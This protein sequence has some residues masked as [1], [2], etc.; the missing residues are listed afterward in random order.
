MRWIPI[1]E[2][3]P[4]KTDMYLCT[5]K[6]RTSI[7]IGV[8]EQPEGQMSFDSDSKGRWKWMG[9]DEVIAWMPLPAPYNP[10]DTQTDCPWK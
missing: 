7:I 2:S 3:V 1:N 9:Q 6:G 10:Q 8:W 5:V 4:D